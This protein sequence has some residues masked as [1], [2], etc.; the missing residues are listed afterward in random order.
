MNKVGPTVTVLAASG[1]VDNA[2]G[3]GCATRAGTVRKSID[4]GVTWSTKLSAADG[5]CDGQCNYDI[6]LAIDPNDASKIY[7]GGA[8]EPNTS[9]TCQ[10]LYVKSTDG[11]T[12][13]TRVPGLDAC[14]FVAFGKGN[15]ADTPYVYIHETP[16]GPNAGKMLQAS[17]SATGPVSAPGGQ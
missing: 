5:F 9:N 6:G 2:S 8:L 13:F 7:L 15:T 16:T 11:G 4:G 12:S 3:S 17:V 14:N 1:E 10:Q